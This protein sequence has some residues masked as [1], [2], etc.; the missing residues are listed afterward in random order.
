MN[1]THPMYRSTDTDTSREA[2]ESMEAGGHAARQR[3]EVILA[4]RRYPGK[5]SAELAALTGMDRFAAARRLPEVEREGRAVRGAAR[6]CE[7]TQRSSITWWP[8]HIDA[9]EAA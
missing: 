6:K 2:A 1:T 5:T 3:D 7:Q 4:V 9:G 8:V